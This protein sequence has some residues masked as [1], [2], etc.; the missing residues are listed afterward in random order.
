MFGIP[1][2]Y[3]DH[4]LGAETA[5]AALALGARI[6]EKHLTLD[7]TMAGP[8][9]QASMDPAGMKH[10]VATLH[11]VH[12]ALGD[13]AKRIMPSEE[14]ARSAF[15]RFIVTQ[16][17]L[18]ASHRI[19]AEDLVLKKVTT[20]LPPSSL[21]Q[22]IGARLKHDIPKDTPLTLSMLDWD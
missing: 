21:E 7:R 19:V 3:S 6:F 22:V 10:Y 9:H 16:Q 8:D 14:N 15:R 4:T 5:C 17:D 13:G 11:Q 2:G 20:G 1:V 18:Q 12:L